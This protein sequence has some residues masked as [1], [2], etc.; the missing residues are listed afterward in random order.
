MNQ[1]GDDSATLSIQYY[2]VS[3]MARNS[4]RKST[5]EKTRATSK[6]RIS[7]SGI[8][9]GSAKRAKLPVSSRPPRGKAQASQDYE[10]EDIENL[11]TEVSNEEVSE[12][13]DAES[14]DLSA[15]ED[16]DSNDDDFSTRKTPRSRQRVKGHEK[17]KEPGS[18]GSKKGKT[19]SRLSA[20][21]LAKPG[22]KAG[23]GPGTQVVI[24]KP[25]ARDA[26]DTP[27]SDE[28]IH[29]NTMLFLE[30]LAAN[31]NRQWLKSELSPFRVHHLSNPAR[32]EYSLSI[33]RRAVL[34][35]DGRASSCGLVLSTSAEILA[36]STLSA[37]NRVVR[38]NER[39]IFLCH[40]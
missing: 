36:P 18:T 28:T 1:A 32:Q 23:L 19:G 2:K 16:D 17:E 9:G 21:E 30:D 4:G 14:P 26:G 6:R 31:N 3:T 29:P 38:R 20:K 15:D 5:A 40:I 12:F 35:R 11:S 24:K 13:E 33:S 34:S 8:A 7:S 25:K 10:S 37:G 22:V 39:P 27:Y